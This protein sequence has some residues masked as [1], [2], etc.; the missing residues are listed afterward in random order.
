MD[1]RN[2]LH[3]TTFGYSLAA[4]VAVN[5][6]IAM[7]YY[8]RVAASMWMGDVRAGQ[9]RLQ[10]GLNLQFVVLALSVATLV[11]GVVPGLITDNVQDTSVVAD[12]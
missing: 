8:L 1:T 5:S 11:F 2:V 10:P 6:V 7:F 4:F 9:A 3:I 12:G